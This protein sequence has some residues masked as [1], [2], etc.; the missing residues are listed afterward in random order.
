MNHP[1]RSEWGQALAWIPMNAINTL[2]G[3]IVLPRDYEISPNYGGLHQD[4]SRM[5]LAI[6]VEGPDIPKGE[7]GDVLPQL[8]V[9]THTWNKVVV[10]GWNAN[11]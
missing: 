2:A 10:Y 7:D 11:R 9:D 6:L 8:I 1:R 4:P 3:G 5:A